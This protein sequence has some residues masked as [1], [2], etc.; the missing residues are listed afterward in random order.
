MSPDPFS[1]GK[2]RQRETTP[3]LEDQT[4]SHS[5]FPAIYPRRIICSLTISWRVIY[6]AAYVLCSCILCIFLVLTLGRGQTFF[7]K[8]AMRERVWLCETMLWGH[9]SRQK[10]LANVV[11]MNQF[12]QRYGDCHTEGKILCTTWDRRKMHIHEQST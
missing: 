2:G 10:Y 5:G 8:S 12:R 9:A 3:P 7:T 4:V 6:K 11:L 1:L